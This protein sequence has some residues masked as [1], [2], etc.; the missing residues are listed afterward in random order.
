MPADV[1]IQR[2]PNTVPRGK[3]TGNAVFSK[4]L[5]GPTRERGGSTTGDAGHA[6][7]EKK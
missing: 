6:D 5:I 1:D 3:N 4:K 7:E 2:L